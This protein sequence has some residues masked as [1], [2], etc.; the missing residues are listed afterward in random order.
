MIGLFR[1][2]VYSL[3][4]RGIVPSLCHVSSFNW[5]CHLPSTT[6][7]VLSSPLGLTIADT[8]YLLKKAW[9]S[10]ASDPKQRALDRRASRWGRAWV[11]LLCSLKIS[12]YFDHF[13]CVSWESP[14]FFCFPPLQTLTLASSTLSRDQFGASMELSQCHC[15]F[16][17]YLFIS[18]NPSLLSLGSLYL[19]KLKKWKE[20]PNLRLRLWLFALGANSQ[21]CALVLCCFVNL[22]ADCELELC[23]ASDLLRLGRSFE[24]F[25]RFSVLRR[26][27]LMGE[28][29][30]GNSNCVLSA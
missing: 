1:P 6:L 26:T 5:K 12:H 21:A 27:Q 24:I 2:A 25:E 19:R 15:E 17:G 7:H 10:P 23:R 16:M 29:G 3:S 4:E 20:K 9:K 13:I 22:N 18:Q 14:V 30:K 28:L 11:L 8:T